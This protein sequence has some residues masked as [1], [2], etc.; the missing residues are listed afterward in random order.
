MKAVVYSQTG[1]LDVLRLVERPVAEPGR[2]RSA[3]RVRVY[4]TDWKARCRGSG[5]ELAF[6]ELVPMVGTT[7][8]CR[9]AR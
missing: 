6:A 1:G 8:N 2:G 5:G 4:P 9:S 7:W 3:S